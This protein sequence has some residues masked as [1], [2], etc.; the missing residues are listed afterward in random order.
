MTTESP[1]VV[2]DPCREHRQMYIA[3]IKEACRDPGTRSAL[4]AGLR[5]DLDHVRPMHRIVARWLPRQR[6]VPEAEER[7]YYLIASMIADRPRHT[8][9][10]DGTDDLSD[11]TASVPGTASV[12]D[13]DLAV[14][15]AQSPVDGPST[16][17]MAIDAQ[18]VPSG[19]RWGRSLGY[20]LAQAV[21][22]SPG[23]EHTMRASAAEAR[24]HLLS[25]QSSAGLHRHL[26]ATVR[27][28]RQTDTDVDW[29]RLME[30]MIAWPILSGRI[31]R[32]WLQ[33]YYW[34][35]TKERN[36]R[37]DEGDQNDLLPPEPDGGP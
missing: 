6:H 1:Q 3:W 26:P 11:E 19:Q 24:L 37:S 21:I 18:R 36:R 25:R 30:D 34:E 32:R 12:E 29:G 20:S 28:L 35:T 4:R 16:R 9:A 2:A 8:F 23:H 31:S 10:T 5:R 27:F 13:P 15:S 17:S 14:A 22:L 7:A 33:D